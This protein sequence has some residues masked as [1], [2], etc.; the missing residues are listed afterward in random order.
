MKHEITGSMILGETFQWVSYN[1]NSE[2]MTWRSKSY[3]RLSYIRDSTTAFS[4]KFH[5][6]NAKDEAIYH[7]NAIPCK[8]GSA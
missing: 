2:I 3:Q 7:L 5:S 6:P 1:G 4:D 8:P